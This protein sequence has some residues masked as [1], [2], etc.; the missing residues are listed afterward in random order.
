MNHLALTLT[1]SSLFIAAALPC[2][3]QLQFE[4]AS[5]KRAE[6]CALQ[7]TIDPAMIALH[8]DPLNV[9]LMEAYSVKVDQIVGPSWLD[10][11][12]YSIDATLPQGTSKDQLPA[13]LQALLADRFKLA[14]H[15]ESKVRSGYALVVDKNGLKVRAAD[16][17]SSTTRSGQITFG[18]G[19]SSQIKGP[20]TMARL[21]RIVSARL[22]APVEDLTGLN[23]KIRYRCLMVARL[24]YRKEGT[25]RARFGDRSSRCG[26]QH[27]QSR[28]HQRRHIRGLSALARIAVRSS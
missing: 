3:G 6:R 8:G 2:A 28:R 9:I 20:M 10:S 23:G 18:V 11:D 4:V 17:N 22:D 21:A 16:P 13:M 19:A 1:M 14:V 7:N 27:G 5:V 24:V 26:K 25:F 15:K 12:C